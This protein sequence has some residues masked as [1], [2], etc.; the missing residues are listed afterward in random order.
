M[1]VLPQTPAPE[2]SEAAVVSAVAA[3]ENCRPDPLLPF[4]TFGSDLREESDF[5][6]G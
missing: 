1:S 4:Y 2:P 3:Q 5:T 6:Q